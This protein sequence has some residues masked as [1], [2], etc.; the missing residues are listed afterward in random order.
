MVKDEIYWTDEYLRYA[1]YITRQQLES[2]KQAEELTE[3]KECST[4]ETENS[5]TCK[6]K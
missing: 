2:A 1:K 4:L 5:E 3:V 6:N